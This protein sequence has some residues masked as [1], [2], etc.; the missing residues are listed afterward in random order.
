MEPFYLKLLAVQVYNYI[1]RG[2]LSLKILLEKICIIVLNS[3]QPS[4]SI[5][6]YVCSGL[7]NLTGLECVLTQHGCYPIRPPFFLDSSVTN[8]Y[9]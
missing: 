3:D 8:S 9:S 6:M 7:K 2:V 1:E 4:W 5:F